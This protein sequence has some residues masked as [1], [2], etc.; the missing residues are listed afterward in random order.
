MKRDR[1]SGLSACFEEFIEQAQ[2]LENL[3]TAAGKKFTADSMAR[4]KRGFVECDGGI[5]LP[6]ANAECES[7]KASS[8]DGH[9]AGH[10]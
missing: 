6:Q 1:G 3:Q 7:G 4:V 10:P 8:D 9:G 2:L 5:G